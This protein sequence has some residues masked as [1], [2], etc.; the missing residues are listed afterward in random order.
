VPIVAG[1]VFIIIAIF[2]FI[3]SA[4]SIVTYRYETYNLGLWSVVG[5]P[6][7]FSTFFTVCAAVLIKSALKFTSNPAEHTKWGAIILVFSLITISPIALSLLSII[8]SSTG[9]VYDASSWFVSFMGFFANI[10][11]LIGILGGVTMLA[12]KPQPLVP[13][14][15]SYTQGQPYMALNPAD[16]IT[17]SNEGI[18]AILESGAQ[19]LIF[20]S[21]RLIIMKNRGAV[22]GS[23]IGIVIMVVLIIFFGYIIGLIVGLV[24]TVIIGVLIGKPKDFS[25]VSVESIL[26]MNHEE[27]NYPQVEKVELK[28][29]SL[30]FFYVYGGARMKKQFVIKN[31]SL[32]QQNLAL[33]NSVLPGRVIEK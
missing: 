3:M 26:S 24:A 17:S 18:L 8:A 20:T 10:G 9:P 14:P 27:I 22:A 29:G 16:I 7:L 25:K 21:R 19:S 32:H 2:P 33:L 13:P 5:L 12:Y 4:I 11:S 23:A 6:I 15:P 1:I 31:G 28:Y 30:K